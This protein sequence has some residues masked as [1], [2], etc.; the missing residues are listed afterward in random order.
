MN[1]E[2]QFK[3]AQA[4]EQQGNWPLAKTSYEAVLKENPNHE[5]SLYGLAL[6]YAQTGDIKWAKDLFE[7]I[8]IINPKNSGAYS[9]LGNCY[10]ELADLELA[11]ASFEKAIEINPQLVDAHYNLGNTFCRMN[12]QADAITC[13]LNAQLLSPDLPNIKFNLAN[14]YGLEGRHV[15]AVEIYK[16]IEPAYSGN[17]N[18]WLYLGCAQFSLRNFQQ[19]NECFFK[20][21]SLKEFFPEAYNELARLYTYLGKHIEAADIYLKAVQQA[22]DNQTYLENTVKGYMRIGK[23]Y[24]AYQLAQ[25]IISPSIRNALLQY[26]SSVL[27]EWTNFDYLNNFILEGG[28]DEISGWDL[29]RIT[30]SAEKQYTLMK[31]YMLRNFPV[32]IV[33]GKATI[34]AR[35]KKIKIAYYSP[36][37]RNHAVMHLAADIFKMHNR[38]AFEVYAFSMSPESRVVEHDSVTRLFDHY[39]EINELSDLEVAKKTRELGIDIAVDLTGN[40]R[41]LRTNIFALRVAPV[42]VNYLGYTGTLAAEYYDYIIADRVVIPPDHQKFYS[43]KLAYLKS[44]MPRQVNLLPSPKLITRTQVNLPPEGFIF[45]CF[46]RGFKFN[47]TVFAS[48]MR[49]LKAVPL[50]YLWFNN[51]PPETILNLKNEARKHGVDPERLLL[52]GYS[53]NM[54]THLARHRLAGLFLDTFP[55]NAHTTASDAL[56]SGLPVVTRM[57]DSFASRVA[58]SLLT[59]IGLPELITTTIEDYESLAISLANDPERLNI[60]RR[61]LKENIKTQRLFDMKKYMVEYE[62]ILAKMYTRAF[63]SE[64]P[65]FID[66]ENL[67]S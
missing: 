21:I 26:L 5:L 48:W 27:C 57:G 56:W 58:A 37:F 13:Y 8:I 10:T 43:E 28:S 32:N 45:C 39:F 44:F 34:R 61:K 31:S 36:D 51:L 55:Y 16:K 46:N 12:R 65:E 9:N 19:A 25:K 18:Y 23:F 24:D 47:P 38:E 53:Q 6:I 54:E 14:S 49:I 30:D 67:S 33:L 3:Q 17:P 2:S 40:T 50:S 59:A 1:L 66:A 41:D 22:P 29:L 7:K 42:Q 11:R 52:A 64:T 63:A 15:E 62:A 4:Y 60:L 20:A 35:S